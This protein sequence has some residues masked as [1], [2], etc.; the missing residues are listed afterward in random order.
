MLVV[1]ISTVA[2]K[3]DFP[4]VFSVLLSVVHFSSCSLRGK[5]FFSLLDKK[6][7]ICALEVMG[8]IH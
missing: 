3:T 7:I 5:W 4:V 1:L 8:S 2:T 6:R